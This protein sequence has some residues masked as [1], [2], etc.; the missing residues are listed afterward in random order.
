VKRR[1]PM[2][3]RLTSWKVTYGVALALLAATVWLRAID[4]APLQT[5]ENN[6]FDLYQNIKPRELPDQPLKVR[7]VDLDEKSVGALGQWPWP[8]NIF[9]E[10]VAKLVD[11]YQVASVGFDIVFAEP[12]RLT[13]DQ[14]I[15]SL[16]GLDDETVRSLMELTNNDAL[17]AQAIS[18]APVVLGQVASNEGEL[19]LDANKPLKAGIAMVTVDQIG[20]QRVGAAGISG[21]DHIQRHREE[22]PGIV[23]KARALFEHRRGPRHI[24]RTRP[25]QRIEHKDLAVQF[26][27]FPV[28][29]RHDEGQSQVILGAVDH[30]G[31]H[32]KACIP[33]FAQAD[34]RIGRRQRI[35]LILDKPAPA[36]V[37]LL[38]GKEPLQGEIH[39][40]I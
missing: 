36:S 16:V 17:L 13:P 14:L 1:L 2:I 33:R 9:A 27:A 35:G 15:D 8:R 7:I 18:G 19:P 3:K 30:P 32:R 23:I 39:C 38:L 37:G 10:L 20:D 12:D 34:E 4:P 40:Q 31:I 22:G 24:R 25:C 6:T 5:L 28:Q 26:P 21:I 29:P 11:D